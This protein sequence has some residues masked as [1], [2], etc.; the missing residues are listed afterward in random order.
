MPLIKRKKGPRGNAPAGTT[1]QRVQDIRLENIWGEG[2]K[3]KI[4]FSPSKTQRLAA[5]Y[6]H[7]QNILKISYC[8]LEVSTKISGNP[9]NKKCLQGHTVH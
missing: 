5:C 9:P 2:V 8:C 6:R 7:T 1:A 4:A 3:I